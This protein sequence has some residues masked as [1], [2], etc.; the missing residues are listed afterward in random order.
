[1]NVLEKMTKP[2]QRQPQ[3]G[4]AIGA[5]PPPEAANDDPVAKARRRRIVIMGGV[6]TLAAAIGIYVLSHFIGAEEN[7]SPPV[8]QTQVVSVVALTAHAFTPHV[9]LLGEVRPKR[10]IHVFAPA[11]GV[12]VLQ[13]LADEGDTVRQGQPLARLD[14]ALASAQTSAARASVAEAESNALRARDEYQRAESIRNSGAL[15]SEAIEQRHAA[16]VAADAR[17]AAARAQ[18]AEVNARLQGGY[19]RAPVAGLVISRS[20]QLGAMVDQ[21]EMFRIAGDNR[22]EVSAQISETDVVSLQVGQTAVFR[23]ADGSTVQGT[24][25]RVPASISDRTRTGEALFDLPSDTRV[26]AGMH[27]SGE[28]EL[29]QRQ[30]LAAPQDSIR[31][32][33]GRAYV[34]VVSPDRRVHKTYVTLGARQGDLVEIIGGV[35]VGANIAGSGSAFLRDGDMVRSAT[36]PA[37]QRASDAEQLRGRQ[38]G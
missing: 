1:M 23:L 9:S 25:S 13:L 12:R 29:A 4:E 30:A 24:L 20:V 33:E 26:R 35:A 16:S 15:S 21:Q 36:G 6:V 22:L 28:I 37:P 10:D 8:D 11:S 38:D 2:L 32:E 3:T 19:V 34:F 7:R 31:Y 17:L 5:S 14:V 18:L 27:L